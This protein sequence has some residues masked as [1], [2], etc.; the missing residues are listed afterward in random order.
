MSHGP[1]TPGTVAATIVM[2]IPLT[3]IILGI[4]IACFQVFHDK[5]MTWLGLLL[6]LVAVGYV[7][8]YLFSG[9]HK[10]H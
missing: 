3:L 6:A 2:W 10:R 1:K 8:T 4:I 7:I 5:D 9:R